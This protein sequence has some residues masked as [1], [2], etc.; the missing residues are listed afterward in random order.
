MVI[1]A[2][3]YT[4]VR[5]L[6]Y[7]RDR[8]LE[9]QDDD[10]FGGSWAWRAPATIARGTG[11]IEASLYVILKR[12]RENTWGY[13][14]AKHFTAEQMAD[15]RPHWLYRINAKGQ[16]YLNR[17]H[18]WYKYEEQA[19]AE[20]EKHYQENDDTHDQFNLEPRCI[21]WHIKPSK[22]ATH[23]EWPFVTKR[24]AGPA[25][26]HMNG[27]VVADLEEAVAL[28]RSL[29]KVMPSKECIERARAWQNAYVQEALEKIAQGAG[30][31]IKT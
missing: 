22:W 16:A 28:A 31:E 2:R 4:K 14:E 21:S 6:L 10:V 17:L 9:V 3:N 25:M 19:K 5:V 13:V 7:L 18:K 8:L 29:F 12:W 27:Y 24:D 20:L 11:V 30:Y 26:W 23:I 15:G 1:E